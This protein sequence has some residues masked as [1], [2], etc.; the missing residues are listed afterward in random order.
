MGKSAGIS[1]QDRRPQGRRRRAYR[2]VFTRW[3]APRRER[4]L[5]R[6]LSECSIPHLLPW[7]TACPA[8]LCRLTFALIC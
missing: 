4:V 5:Q 6:S 7:G 3:I 8:S 1:L 2:D